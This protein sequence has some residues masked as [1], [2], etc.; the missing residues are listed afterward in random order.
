MELENLN[1]FIYFKNKDLTNRLDYLTNVLNR[2]TVFDY[3]NYLIDNNV[4]FTICVSD[5]DNFKNINDTYG[6]LV[7]DKILK[8]VAYLF[9]KCISG[10]G[11]VGRFGGDEFIFVLENITEYDDVWKIC[12]NINMEL[13]KFCISSTGNIFISATTGVSRFPKDAKGVD[14]LFNTADKALYRGK[15][16]GRN[17]FIIYLPE[18]H[19]NIEIHSDRSSATGLD[20]LISKCY[21]TL[22]ASLDIEKQID[23]LFKGIS[24]QLMYDHICIETPTCT[25]Y[26]YCHALAYNQEFQHID[27]KVL[28]NAIANIGVFAVKDID[29]LKNINHQFYETFKK[30]KVCS[31]LLVKISVFGKDY[32]VIRVDSTNTNRVWQQDDI[33]LFMSVANT[34]ALLL[35]DKD[36]TL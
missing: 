17:C 28:N 8:G 30:Q 3:V 32:G 5:I 25:K 7:G 35:H 15:K 4:P 36:L 9:E 14:D 1:K 12:H 6:H 10:K 27:V 16:K 29:L 18:K 2:Q 34:I 26:E 13:T 21:K 33:I 31:T 23:V 19:Q 11:V 22:T 24:N 20:V